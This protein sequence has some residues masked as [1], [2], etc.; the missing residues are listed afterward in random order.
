MDLLTQVQLEMDLQ[1]L[2]V[3]CEA[4][5]TQIEGV[6]LDRLVYFRERGG[7]WTLSIADNAY[8]I[9]AKQI[10]E[11]TCPEFMSTRLA[12]DLTRTLIRIHFS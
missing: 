6:V 1:L 3:T 10:A 5:P 11:G 12:M 9:G 2:Q 8:R 7:N 4:A